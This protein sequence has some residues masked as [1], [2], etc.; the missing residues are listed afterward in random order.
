MENE[1]KRDGDVQTAEAEGTPAPLSDSLAALA[2]QARIEIRTYKRGSVESYAAYLRAGAILVKARAEAQHGEWEAVLERVGIEAR[3]ALNMMTLAE[4]GYTGETL[5]EAGGVNAALAALRRKSGRGKSESDS[6]FHRT[7]EKGLCV[8][9]GQPGDCRARCDRCG[10]AFHAK[11]PKLKEAAIAGKGSRLSAA[12]VSAL[13]DAVAWTAPPYGDG[14]GSE[15]KFVGAEFAKR[16][17]RRGF[18][19]EGM[20]KILGKLYGAHPGFVP[21]AEMHDAAG[22]TPQQF[23]ALMEWFGRRL[24]NADGDNESGHFFDWRHDDDRGVWEC[25]LPDTV[26]RAMEEAFPDTYPAPDSGVDGSGATAGSDGNPSS[27]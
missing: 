14:N 8:D 23:A 4:A 22:Y 6:D 27:V 24:A 5:H 18:L 25:R 13:V 26:R 11:L 16:A 9:C 12:E 19:S 1:T 3:T 20:E 10:R 15:G 21:A 2:D 17:L 7:D